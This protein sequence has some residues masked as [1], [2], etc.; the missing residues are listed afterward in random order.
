MVDEKFMNR[1]ASYVFTS[2]TGLLSWEE[3]ILREA[4]TH[5]TDGLDWPWYRLDAKLLGRGSA[6]GHSSSGRQCRN[7]LEFQSQSSFPTLYLRKDQ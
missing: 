7:Q 4:G 1:H 5:C 2:P 6:I 3:A